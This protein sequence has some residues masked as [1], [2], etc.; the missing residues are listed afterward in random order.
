MPQLFFRAVEVDRRNIDFTLVRTLFPG[1][2]TYWQKQAGA[3]S[4]L[5][6]TIR[7]DAAEERGEKCTALQ[8]AMQH[9]AMD[10]ALRCDGQ[11]SALR[12]PTENTGM[13][14]RAR[15]AMAQRSRNKKTRLY[16][17][18]WDAAYARAGYHFSPARSR[19]M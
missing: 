19:T 8:W 17:Q 3:A 4:C 2:A 18:V 1:F 5:R 10:N 16:G 15:K 13:G 14:W 7:L 11:C 6:E 9:A 12:H